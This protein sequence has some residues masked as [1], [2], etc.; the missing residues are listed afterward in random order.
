MDPRPSR[1]IFAFLT[2]SLSLSTTALTI[3][4]SLI[5][6][7]ARDDES[8]NDEPVLQ[9]FVCGTSRKSL[10]SDLGIATDLL[11]KLLNSSGPVHIIV[12]GLDEID[13]DPRRR[14]LMEI[15]KVPRNPDLNR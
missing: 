10:S 3:I 9:T 4:H 2:H 5:F 15:L 14:F 1:I 12:D 7:L 13:E 6:Q 11:I 8:A